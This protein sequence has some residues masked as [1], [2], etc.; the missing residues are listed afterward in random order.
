MTRSGDA[1]VFTKNRERSLA[2]DVARA[3]FERVVA[4]PHATQMLS[5]EHFTVDGARIEAWAGLKSFR[6]KDTPA[7][8][9]DDPG[10]PTANFHGER[11]SNATHASSR[12]TPRTDAVPLT[13]ALPVIRAI[14]SVSRSA[15][16]WKKSSGGRRPS[17]CF[18]KRAIA[19]C[20]ASAGCSPLRWPC[21]TWSGFGI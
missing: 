12:K 19:G 13:A 15:S 10:N 18:V 20:G 5:A 6:R 4:Q 2:G 21:T 14:P 17:V 8:P 9:P 1:T 16:G 3:F 7:A 11:R